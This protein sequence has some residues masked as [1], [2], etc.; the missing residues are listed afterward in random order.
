MG[1]RWDDGNSD[2]QS[3]LIA[4]SAGQRSWTAVRGM[5]RWRSVAEKRDGGIDSRQS[6]VVSG[7]DRK[8][9]LL[10][11]NRQLRT[12]KAFWREKFAANQMRDRF[13]TR[14]L[15]RHGWRVVR[16]W[17]HEL[18]KTPQRCVVKIRETLRLRSV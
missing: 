12:G 2:L 17:E 6:S 14:T 7:C 1:L 10:T 15:R 3:Q 8:R 9:E 4:G 13:V 11:D 18:A 5:R 16:I